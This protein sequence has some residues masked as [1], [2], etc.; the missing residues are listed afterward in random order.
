M[1]V[2]F[3]TIIQLYLK[4]TIFALAKTEL[5]VYVSSAYKIC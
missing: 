2:F 5:P 4:V 1:N 3:K